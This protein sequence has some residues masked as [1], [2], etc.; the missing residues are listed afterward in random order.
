MLKSLSRSHPRMLWVAFLL[1]QLAA[2]G[3][4]RLAVAQPLFAAGIVYVVIFWLLAW[5]RPAVALAL[6]FAAAPW[7]QSL[8]P[9]SPVLFSLTEVNLA[10]MLPV[11]L[12]RCA[13]QKR[14]LAFGPIGVA[15]ALYFVIC[16][17]SS[18]Q[19]WRGR[20]SLV[21]LIQMVLYLVIGLVI[22]SSYVKREEEFLASLRGLIVVGVFFSLVMLA[23]RTNYI[24]DLHKNGVGA[25]VSCA[26]L[27]AVELWFRSQS[28]REK[29][30]LVAAQVVLVAGLLFSLS[31]GSWLGSLVGL[32]W[33]VGMRGQWKMMLRG[34][35]VLLPVVAIGWSSLPET[36]REYATGFGR[37]RFNI[38]ERYRSVEIARGYWEKSPVYGGGV[39]LRERYDA[40]NIA[41]ST[42]AET[43]VL[44]LGA[45]ALI[46][47]A[48]VSGLARAR[49]F[50][51]RDELLFSLLV[52]GGALMLRQVSHGMVDHYWGRGPLTMAWASMG[53]AI[54]AGVAIGKRQQALQ[55]QERAAFAHG[56]EPA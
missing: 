13:A 16:V 40:T 4:A 46:H 11:V 18:L 39:G 20:D 52:I 27:V 28:P 26:F 29:R 9:G 47:V 54:F 43:G 42:L 6:I 55:S 2:V 48:L 56:P 7:Q 1:G 19:T 44:G 15:M 38:S 10:L 37:E 14:R 24:L 21:S 49:R 53:M 32:T 35:L 17:L 22:F 5:N 45:F 34:V 12:A 25:S 3:L 30:W 36:E 41:W 8:V 51:R 50:A 31:R 23:L 33:I